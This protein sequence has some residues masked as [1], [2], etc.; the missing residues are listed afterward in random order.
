MK[1]QEFEIKE[2][3]NDEIRRKYGHKIRYAKDC[4]V[5]ADSITETTNRQISVSTLKRFFGIIKT[6]FNPSQYTL[7]TLAIYLNF[8][9]WEDYANTF[10][11]NKHSFSNLNSWQ[12]LK[13]RMLYITSTSM[14]SIGAKIGRDAC[15]WP[16]REFAVNKID[17]FLNSQ[18]TA[19]AF[20]APD[21][22]GKSTHIYR[23]VE[24]YFTGQN[25]KYP[26][27]IVL[28]IDGGSLV[29][30]VNKYS[31]N[32]RIK[33][34]LS[35]DPGNSFSNYF[36]ENPDEI[37]GRFVLIIDGLNEIFY[38]TDK[39]SGF[40]E[41]LLDIV[42]FYENTPW[43]KLILTAHPDNWKI[44][45]GITQKKTSIRKQWF[46]V[47]FNALV[48][49][50]INIPL[51][52]KKEI[53]QLLEKHHSQKQLQ[54]M[55]FQA[56]HT[57]EVISHPFFLNLF[58][59]KKQENIETDIDLLQDAICNNLF[60]EPFS[61][62]KAAIIDTI[63][64]HSEYGRKITSIDKDVFPTTEEFT[65]AYKDLVAKNILYE[66]TIPG[67]YLSLKTCV[68]FS[69]DIL[70]EFMLANKWLRENK[71]DLNL[72]KRVSDY[73]SDNRQLRSNIIKYLIKIAFRES[74]TELLKDIYS[75]FKVG[76]SNEILIDTLDIDSDALNILTLELR[77][78]KEIR[79]YLIPHYAKSQAGQQFYFEF[80]FD[81][82]ALVLHSG[83]NV[84]YY[85]ENAPRE[86]AQIYGHY[87]K[88]TQFF[89]EKDM[90]NLQAEA[91]WFAQIQQPEKLV[92]LTAGFYYAVQIMS[93]VFLQNR[94]S[95]QLMQRIMKQSE[96]F[97]TDKAQLKFS[98]PIFE[99][100]VANALNYANRFNEIVTVTNAVTDKYILDK[101]RSSWLYELM[102]A[103]YARAL[104][105]TGEEEIARENLKEVEL[106]SVSVNYKY[107]VKLRYYLVQVD[108]LLHDEK[109]GQAI[110]LLD[111]IKSIAKMIKFKYFYDQ[112]STIEKKL[113]SN[114][115]NSSNM[116][117]RKNLEKI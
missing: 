79:D 89:F 86:D 33:N 103:F 13:R 109:T 62:Q 3:I 112:A 43:F 16:L 12:Q 111:E 27:D 105:N 59:K 5:L 39:L 22:Y 9:N 57:L 100:L 88:F 78:H 17:T 69:H 8:E 85:L 98:F 60:S 81:M 65:A 92:P 71:F 61:V 29:N 116:H 1:G 67:Y 23:L 117:G 83:E 4:Q 54:Q 11:K 82:D 55:Y 114:S 115:S 73:Y 87:L 66:Y 45:S 28:L 41:N 99:Y 101:H 64:Q 36:R 26:D 91:G 6:P 77:K 21:G 50:T 110:E 31:S 108:F 90:E 44:L 49:E 19:T 56:P 37:T 72:I 80:F 2:L 63:F 113:K 76:S 74:K 47:S 32:A 106:R 20:I 97:L 96:Q 93:E 95:D 51:L 70:M 94:F 30:M 18:K 102:R 48:N 52:K 34:L 40:I 38:Q 7:D 46:D 104:L 53:K 10:E 35:F 75:I 14:E 25:A 15:E 24:H 84:N 68:N 42:A 107:Y 58:L